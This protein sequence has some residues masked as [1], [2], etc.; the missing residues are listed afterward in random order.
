MT[1][2][3]VQSGNPSLLKNGQV[4]EV[5]KMGTIHNFS[6]VKQATIDAWIETGLIRVIETPPIYVYPPLIE[7]LDYLEENEIKTLGDYAFADSQLIADIPNGIELQNEILRMINPNTISL[8][9]CC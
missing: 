5:F 3:Y 9:N 2:Y 8:D 4:T 6:H 7:Y 1:V